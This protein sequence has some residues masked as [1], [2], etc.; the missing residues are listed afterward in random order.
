MESCD[1][2]ADPGPAQCCGEVRGDHSLCGPEWSWEEY[3]YTAHP[4]L[5]RPQRG[6]GGFDF[7]LHLTRRA[8]STQRIR[9]LLPPKLD[10]SHFKNNHPLGEIEVHDNLFHYSAS[11]PLTA[12]FFTFTRIRGL[13]TPSFLPFSG[14]KWP[15][16]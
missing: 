8:P 7:C 4:A 14:R 12:S 3:R 6:N 13:C 1:L 5:L 11:G 9:R 15:L 10:S 16:V 2:C